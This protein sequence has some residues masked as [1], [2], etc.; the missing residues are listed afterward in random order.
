M[1]ILDDASARIAKALEYAGRYGTIDGSHH[2]A[3]VID[4]MVRALTG[5][6]AVTRHDVDVHDT[7]YTYKSQGESREYREWVSEA[8]AAYGEWDD[9][10]AP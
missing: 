4:Q 5:C 9:G 8:I 2:K 10:I 3:W 1:S 7:E 6:P